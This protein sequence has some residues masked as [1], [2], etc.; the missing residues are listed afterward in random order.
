MIGTSLSVCVSN[1]LD[2]TV[3][4]SDVEKIISRTCA[5][6]PRVE[7]LLE[8]YANSY[9]GAN[10]SEGKEIARRLFAAGKV[11]QPRLE[12]RPNPVGTTWWVKDES[13]IVWTNSPEFLGEV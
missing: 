4:E 13:E 7:E 6:A 1:I 11:E 9:W 10:P 5:P 8:R 12:G 3:A 2:G